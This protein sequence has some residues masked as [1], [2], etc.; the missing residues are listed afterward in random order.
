MQTWLSHHA[1]TAFRI[2][3]GWTYFSAFWRR[4]I[5]ENKLNP[6]AGNYLGIKFNAFWP[7]ALLIKDS[8]RWFLENPEALYLQ[9]FAFTIIEAIV[10][11][12]LI[13][14]L[15]TRL[16]AFGASLLAL[17]I[18]LGAGWL[19]TTCL[20]EWQIGILGI[21]GGLAILYQGGGAVALDRLQS[22]QNSPIG[23]INKRVAALLYAGGKR[24]WLVFTLLAVVIA[25]GTNQYFHGG[26]WGKLHNPSKRPAYSIEHVRIENEHL[27]FRFART[28]GIDTYGS[29]ILYV[30][31]LSPQEKQLKQLR[32]ED[33][34]SEDFSIKNRLI[35]KIS[36]GKYALEVPLGAEADIEYTL[37]PALQQQTI[38]SVELVD[39][40]GRK[41]QAEVAP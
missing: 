19:G 1:L 22:I 4:L 26:L 23:K 24:L 8:I 14:G 10:G 12:L 29:F 18:L 15:F 38:G 40:S 35:A 2:I 3:F 6:E 9:L 16:A 20:D 13:L 32:I 33:F 39:V 21:A 28:G 41:W 5:L 36:T 11:L 7:N 37:P 31:L 34:S 17:G 30:N 25:L 27:R